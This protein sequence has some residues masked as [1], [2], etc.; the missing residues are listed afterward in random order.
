[1][2]EPR[3]Y[4]KL[5]VV[6]PGVLRWVH[7]KEEETRVFKSECYLFVAVGIAASGFVLW[8]LYIVFSSP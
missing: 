5:V 7:S 2:T 4:P 3:Q 6:A 8:M 1:M